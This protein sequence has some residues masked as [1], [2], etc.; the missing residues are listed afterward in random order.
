MGF[1]TPLKPPYVFPVAIAYRIS[2][3]L[4]RHGLIFLGTVYLLLLCLVGCAHFHQVIFINNACIKPYKGYDYR[5][6]DTMRIKI[7][8]KKIDIPKNFKTN[9]ASIPRILWPIFAPQY[10]G[11]VAPAILHDYLYHCNPFG[12]RQFADEV[13]YSALITKDVTAFTASKFFMA[14]RLFGGSHY[15]RSQGCAYG[16]HRKSL[17]TLCKRSP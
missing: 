3:R 16:N 4:V 7:D 8:G 9:L 1:L 2:M 5:T 15:N 14:V 11:F 6:C 12:D 13:L 17:S 10:S